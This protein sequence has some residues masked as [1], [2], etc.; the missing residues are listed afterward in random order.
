VPAQF[1]DAQRHATM[2]AGHAAG[3]E[4]IEM[5]NEPVAAALCHV[6]GN[7]GLAFTELAVDQQLLVFDLGG[8]TLDLA[9]VKYTRRTRSASL[10]LPMV[11][12]SLEDW[13]SRISWLM[14]RQKNSW[15]ISAADPRSNRGSLQFS[16][17]GSRTGET[18][19]FRAAARCGHSAA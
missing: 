15:P 13:I 12:W 2:Q 16:E 4:R 1:S 19:P 18:Q 3:L 14:R 8:G 10:W 9:I 6:L 5:I 11:I 17:P 7:E